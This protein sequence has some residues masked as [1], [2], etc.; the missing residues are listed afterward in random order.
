MVNN[1]TNVS[2]A[3]VAV[4]TCSPVLAPEKSH[5]TCA[6]IFGKF[7]FRSSCNVSCDEGYKLRGKATL[8][9]LSDGN[10]SAATPA[11]EGGFLEHT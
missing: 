5:L 1:L 2:Y 11:C 10:W 8:T 9:C 3:F 6:D 4:V 7:S